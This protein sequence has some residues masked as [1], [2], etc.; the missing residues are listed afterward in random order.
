MAVLYLCLKKDI[1]SITILKLVSERDV[2]MPTFREF[3]M[4]FRVFGMNEE[5]AGFYQ[6]VWWPGDVPISH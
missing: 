6:R 3:G 4:S 1:V 2:G 5:H